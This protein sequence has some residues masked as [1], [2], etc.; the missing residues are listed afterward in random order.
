MYDKIDAYVRRLVRESTPEHTVWN[1]EKVRQGKPSSWN[2][3]DG[4]M[5]TAL[6]ALAEITGEEAYFDFA[7]RYIDWF[8]DSDGGIRS[9]DPEKFN[10]DDINEG[11]VLFPLYARTGK[12]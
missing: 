1:I 12:E 2:Y 5:I 10:L 4:C 9:Y 7:E 3:I 8:V 6:L 11:R